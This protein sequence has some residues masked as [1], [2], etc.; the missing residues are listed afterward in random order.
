[1][2]R[3]KSSSKSNGSESKK[4]EQKRTTYKAVSNFVTDGVRD[5][6]TE[7]RSY[8]EGPIVALGNYIQKELEYNDNYDLDKESLTPF[9]AVLR[10]GN[11]EIYVSVVWSDTQCPHCGAPRDKQNAWCDACSGNVEQDLAAEL[12]AMM[13]QFE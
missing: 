8:G 7:N 1:M 13:E 4:T 12:D 5:Y 10:L 6:R 3:G 2:A 11:K 9:G